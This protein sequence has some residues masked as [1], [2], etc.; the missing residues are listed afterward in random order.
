M[1]R[2]GYV[3]VGGY[4]GSGVDRDGGGVVERVC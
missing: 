1:G 4:M 3:L 2:E